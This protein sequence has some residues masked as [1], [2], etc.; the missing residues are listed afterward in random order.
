MWYSNQ[1]HLS[2]VKLTYHFSVLFRLNNCFSCKMKLF[3]IVVC[4][5]FVQVGFC[6]T[7]K[8]LHAH[9]CHNLTEIGSYFQLSSSHVIRKRDDSTVESVRDHVNDLLGVSIQFVEDVDVVLHEFSRNAF[10]IESLDGFV[11]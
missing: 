1:S 5:C 9:F 8:I 3:A 10:V 7:N 6:L 2:F 11:S 4:I